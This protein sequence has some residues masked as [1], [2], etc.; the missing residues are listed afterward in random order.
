METKINGD[1]RPYPN[2]HIPDSDRK[3]ILTEFMK[4]YVDD[5]TSQMHDF[6]LN[7]CSDSYF[8]QL[9]KKEKYGSLIKV[10]NFFNDF[11]PLIISNKIEHFYEVL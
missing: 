9:F 6:H 10:R 2:F 5:E 4:S 7:E 11:R 3:Q 1:H 8:D